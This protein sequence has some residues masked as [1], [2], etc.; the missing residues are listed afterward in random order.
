VLGRYRSVLAVPGARRLYATGVVARLP[1]G[2]ATLCILLLVHH[3]TRSYALAGLAVGGEALASAAVG[4]AQGRLLD[5]RGQTRILAP[6]AGLQAVLFIA[7]VLAARAHVP[8]G[9]LIVIAWGVG[10]AQPAIAPSVRALL[11]AVISDEDVRDSAYALESVIQELIF[12]IGPLLVAVIVTAAS[13][14]VALLLCAL[15]VVAGTALFVTSPASRRAPTRMTAPGRRRA[16]LRS[17]PDL[18]ALLAPVALMGVS[19]GSLD[20]GLPSLAL[21]AGTRASTALLLAMWSLG[22]MVGGLLYGARDWRWSLS[23]RYRALLTIAVVCAVPLIFARSI[24]AGLIG[25]LLT[26]LTVA[27]VFSCQYALVSRAVS[28]G[29]ETE[30][31][32]WISSALVTGIAVGSALGGTLIDELGVSGPFLLTCAA[33]AVAAYTA[34]GARVITPVTG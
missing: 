30:A 7:L 24:P 14:S 18:R 22:S 33:L 17:H 34:T 10:G 28:E 19:I 31:F 15:V 12:L 3:A 8:S 26:G 27:P 25:A 32:T 13:P 29:T 1:Q 11:G 23:E 5:R 21:H 6:F 9:L 4:P 20:V 16:M 2:M